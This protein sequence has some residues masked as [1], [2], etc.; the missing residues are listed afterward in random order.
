MELIEPHMRKGAVPTSDAQFR[1]ARAGVVPLMEQV[2][3]DVW[4]VG[5]AMPGGHITYS[6]LY[7]LRDAQGAIHV[8]DPGWNSDANWRALEAALDEIGASVGGVASIIATHLHPDHIGMAGRLQEASAAP[9][10]VH[11]AEQRAL[12][13]YA[14]GD[15]SPVTLTQRLREWEVPDDRRPE[16]ERVQNGA[17]DLPGARIDGVL[18]SGRRLDIPGFDLIAMH[19]PGHTPGHLCLREDARSFVLTGDHVLP[20]MH[21]GLW[22][23]GRT[24]TNPLT[25]YLAA[26]AAVAAYPDHEVLPGHGY[27]FEGLLA[28]SK[29][30][31]QHHLRRSREVA[32]VLIESHRPTIWEIASRLTWTAG[33]GNLRG[34]YL[35]SALAQTS[36]HKDFVEM[37]EIDNV[38]D[39]L[40]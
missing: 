5:A 6:L 8:I 10:L 13:T 23:G 26:L 1:S 34:F 12:A 4:A 21:A 25:E 18:T 14:E 20:T 32:A 36:M 33:W 28:R 24:K 9:I 37:G 15:W 30:S 29:Q 19:T 39:I 3:E 7:L 35:Y 27:R 38:A 2:R 40:R 22:L 17:V 31:A 16:L 11:P